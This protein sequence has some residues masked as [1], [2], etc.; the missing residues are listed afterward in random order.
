MCWHKRPTPSTLYPKCEHA[1]KLG[2]E[3]IS[4]TLTLYAKQIIYMNGNEIFTI[5]PRITAQYWDYDS[6]WTFSLNH[7]KMYLM[8]LFCILN[9]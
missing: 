1:Y 8:A 6:N 2:L 5:I 7:T 4:L 3:Y 9:L